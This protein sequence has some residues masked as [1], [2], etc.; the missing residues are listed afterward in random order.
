MSLY[1]FYNNYFPDRLD[2]IGKDYY[3]YRFKIH[4]KN[5]IFAVIGNTPLKKYE[6][7]NYR[8]NGILDSI[9]NELEIVF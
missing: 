7:T 9:K 8:Q 4:G 1:I 2:I 6:S 5:F 3:V